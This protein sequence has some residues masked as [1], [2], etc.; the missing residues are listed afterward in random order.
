MR[1]EA[2]DLTLILDDLVGPAELD[3][4]AASGAFWTPTP[5]D[6]SALHELIEWVNQ[7]VFGQAA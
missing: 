7:E 5:D 2:V 1:E 6:Q 4:A 3:L